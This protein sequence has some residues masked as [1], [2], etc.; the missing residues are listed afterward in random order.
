MTYA[1]EIERALVRATRSVTPYELYRERI[2]KIM[3]A[4]SVTPRQA[5]RILSK[6]RRSKQGRR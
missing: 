1:Q 2:R 3:D 6:A 4:T 5:A